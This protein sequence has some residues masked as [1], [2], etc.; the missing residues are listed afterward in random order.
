MRKVLEVP[1]YGNAFLFAMYLLILITV[2]SFLSDYITDLLQK[3]MD[4]CKIGSQT[5]S[6]ATPK[7]LCS[8]Y[9]RPTKS[10]AIRQHKSRFRS[11]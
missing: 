4:L 7:P 3:T 9:E 6:C 10:D 1:T 11:Q 8:E 5:S 2:C